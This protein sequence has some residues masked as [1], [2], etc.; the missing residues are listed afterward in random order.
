MI[1]THS[2]TFKKST[3]CRDYIGSL[4][5]KKWPYVDGHR[6]TFQQKVTLCSSHV[7]QSKNNHAYAHFSLRLLLLNADNTQALRFFYT[8]HIS[9]ARSGF[10]IKFWLVWLKSVTSMGNGWKVVLRFKA[11]VLKFQKLLFILQIQTLISCRRFV[12]LYW[13]KDNPT[14]QNQITSRVTYSVNYYVPNF[15]YS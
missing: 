12:Q 1:L 8:V 7:K 4:F 2:A 9:L 5:I 3:L 11:A 10:L 6:A 13:R 14:C 15:D